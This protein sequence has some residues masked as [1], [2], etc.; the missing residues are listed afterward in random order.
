VDNG[1]HRVNPA[2]VGPGSGN[3]PR[4]P[5][6][7]PTLLE[8]WLILKPWRW[9]IA[10]VGAVSAILV[11]VLAKF[12]MTQWYLAT[13]VIRPASQQGPVSPLANVV[14][15][16]SP[17]GALS[18]LMSGASGLGGMLPSDA[19]EYMG[20]SQSYSFTVALVERHKLGPMLKQQSLIHR[21]FINPPHRALAAVEGIFESPGPSDERWMW[22]SAMQKRF[23]IEY[24]DYMGDLTL[25]FKDRDPATAKK[26]LGFY[27]QDLRDT[28]R[29]R[30]IKDTKTVVE[31]LE[32][33]LDQ[34]SDPLVQQ[35]LA[36][37]LASEIQQEKTAE[38][39][40]DFAFS[41][42]DAPYAPAEV[43]SPKP[44]LWAVAAGVMAPFMLCLWLLFFA[45]V[46]EPLRAAES[47]SDTGA[48]NGAVTPIGVE[49]RREETESQRV[50]HVL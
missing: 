36:A 41:E 28:L 40:A 19:A 27:I 42:T 25:T 31:S 16:L 4:T 20:L 21:I 26:V 35:Q 48:S 33:A 11:F 22:Y 46:Y 1:I 32:K 37:L 14:G 15:T 12:L 29:A 45:R 13:A 39:Q 49:A 43:Y 23:D 3:R 9:R 8:Y 18:S 17:G 34:T 47:R 50:R 6:E 38:A 5:D 7:Y 10:T 44:T 2:W 24:N 30:S